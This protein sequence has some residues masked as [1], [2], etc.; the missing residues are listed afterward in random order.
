MLASVV[1]L[2]ATILVLSLLVTNSLKGIKRRFLNGV[3]QG[4]MRIDG[5]DKELHSCVAHMHP[6]QTDTRKLV[7]RIETTHSI[8]L[9]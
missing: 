4:D 5:V 7:F 2:L 9:L 8:R 1:Y 6:T 3:C